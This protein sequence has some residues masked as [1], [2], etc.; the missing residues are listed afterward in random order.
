MGAHIGQGFGVLGVLVLGRIDANRMV[1]RANHHLSALY[2][3]MKQVHIAQKPVHKGA[4]GVVPH[5]LGGANLLYLTGVH[6][7]H[8]VGHL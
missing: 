5:L 2:A 6:Q 8:A 3:T 7:H 4:G 1:V